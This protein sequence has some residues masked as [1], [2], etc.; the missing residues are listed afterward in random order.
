MSPALT[1]R[2]LS[3]VSSGKSLNTCALK[4]LF[5]FVHVLFLLRLL[6]KEMSIFLYPVLAGRILNRFS[7]DIGHMDDSLPL[8]FQDFIQVMYQSCCTSPEF[9]QG[10]AEC[11]FL[12]DFSQGLEVGLSPWWCVLLSSVRGCVFERERCGCDCDAELTWVTPGAGVATQS[13]Q[14]SSE[15]TTCWVNGS[16]S[17]FQVSGVDSLY[18]EHIS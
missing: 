17:A 15:A 2:F 14:C 4:I 7:K 3:T 9:S 1:S 18:C 5:W 10:R 8:I 13:C 12:K 11:L 6:Y 16:P